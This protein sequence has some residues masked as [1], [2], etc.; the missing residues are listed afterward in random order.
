MGLRI[1]NKVS[2]CLI[3]DGGKKHGSG[4]MESNVDERV[5]KGPRVS[6]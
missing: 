1:D 3:A 6:I 5:A 2:Q 4:V